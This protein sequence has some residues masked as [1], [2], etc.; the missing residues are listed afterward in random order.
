MNYVLLISLDSLHNK[1]RSVPP[2]IDNILGMAGSDFKEIFL[3]PLS[4]N[5]I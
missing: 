1:F 5:L 2:S 3:I 4:N